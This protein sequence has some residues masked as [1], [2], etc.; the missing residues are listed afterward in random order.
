[1]TVFPPTNQNRVRRQPT[2]G[3]YDVETIHAIV[4]AAFVCHVGFVQDGHPYV[5]PTLH[6]RR[7]DE[8]LL[9]GA[10]SSRL[11]RHAAA[12]FPLA[13]TVTHVDG[14]VLARSVFN[15]SINYRSAVL[16][17]KGR[18]IDEPAAKLAALRAFTDRLLPGRWDD[19]RRPTETEMKATAVVAI[20]IE[21][22]SAKIRTGPPGDDEDDYGRATWA[23]VLP[24]SVHYGPLQAD[25]R[26]ADDIEIPHYLHNFVQRCQQDEEQ[27]TT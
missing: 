23:G 13:I 3:H 19:V 24:L 22:A 25:P 20:T 1:M 17:G 15:H 27:S 10:S 7:G 9:H 26:L 18:L 8:I 21:K 16:F 4:D 11:M 12:G 14:I 5:I 6:A 2:R